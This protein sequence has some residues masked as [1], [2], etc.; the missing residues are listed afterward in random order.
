M[1]HTFHWTRHTEFSGLNTHACHVVMNILA[2]PQRLCVVIYGDRRNHIL[3][4]PDR[5]IE[6]SRLLTAEVDSDGASDLV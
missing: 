4:G 5:T 3:A 6:L 2:G 1:T